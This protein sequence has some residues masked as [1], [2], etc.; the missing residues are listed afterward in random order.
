MTLAEAIGIYERAAAY[1]HGGPVY[2]SP[3]RGCEP[4]CRRAWLRYCGVLAASRRVRP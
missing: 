4:Y 3:G 1:C 2:S